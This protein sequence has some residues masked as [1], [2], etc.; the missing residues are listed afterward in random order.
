MAFNIYSATVL[1]YRQ[2]TELTP[3]NDPCEREPTLRS[4]VA[5]YVI[6]F[7]VDIYRHV[8]AQVDS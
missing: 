1:K 3:E 7:I 6:M 8:A 4:A 5:A 2:Y